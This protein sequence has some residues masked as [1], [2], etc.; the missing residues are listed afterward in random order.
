[1]HTSKVDFGV[2]RCTLPHHEQFVNASKEGDH[3]HNPQRQ[4][5]QGKY[6]RHQRRR[7]SANSLLVQ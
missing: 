5:L 2:T 6:C 7:L 1:M 3:A 4:D